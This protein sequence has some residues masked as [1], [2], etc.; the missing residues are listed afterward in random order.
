M[1]RDAD[2]P[3]SGGRARARTRRPRHQ[4]R[5]RTRQRGQGTPSRLFRRRGRSR[6][7]NPEQRGARKTHDGGASGLPT[8]LLCET[9]SSGATRREQSLLTAPVRI[10]VVISV[11]G[12]WLPTTPAGCDR[13]DLSVGGCGVVDI[14][15]LLTGR[16]VG[17]VVVVRSVVGDVEPASPVGLDCVDLIVASGDEVS[18]GYAFAAGSVVGP[19]VP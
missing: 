16:R 10:A 13:I 3:R 14:G 4:G 7:S 18:I 6:Q 11:V 9:H 2:Y 19:F 5:A 15:Y 8:S 1:S 17:R 12:D